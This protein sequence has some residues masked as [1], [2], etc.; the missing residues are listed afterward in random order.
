MIYY[1]VRTKGV[2]TEK[3]PYKGHK[4][5]EFDDFYSAYMYA[6]KKKRKQEIYVDASY[7][8]VEKNAAYAF[9][10][11]DNGNVIYTQSGII[12]ANSSNEAELIGALKVLEFC[13]KNKIKDIIINYDNSSIKYFSISEYG[14]IEEYIKENKTVL[15][16]RELQERMYE[17]NY[18]IRFNKVKSH[19][20]SYNKK[21]DKI[22]SQERKKIS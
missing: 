22:A 11:V 3:P 4:I 17:E 21:V 9:I 1:G 10:F 2:Y 16:F 6:Y 5:R 8:C 13:H 14:G 7:S 15:M 18:I 20:N 12:E 19:S